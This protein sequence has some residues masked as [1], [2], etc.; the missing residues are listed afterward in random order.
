MAEKQHEIERLEAVKADIERCMDAVAAFEYTFLAN[1]A[2]SHLD[3]ALGEM[4]TEVNGM[5]R[6]R[7]EGWEV[8]AV[9]VNK[10][11]CDKPGTSQVLVTY[12]NEENAYKAMR[13][14]REQGV[15]RWGEGKEYWW[16]GVRRKVQE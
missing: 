4:Y 10:T 16:Y 6:N 9:A 12:D 11:L 14:M 8:Y 2:S 15:A 5:L 1:D 3:T 7:K 13:S